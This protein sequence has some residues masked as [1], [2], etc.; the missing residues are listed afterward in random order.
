MS[1]QI[2]RRSFETRG[3]LDPRLAEASLDRWGRSLYAALRVGD[4]VFGWI[5]A[6]ARLVR[7][8]S[9]ITS[10]VAA[11][12]TA[13]ITEPPVP[14]AQMALIAIVVIALSNGGFALN[15]V[16]DRDIDKINQPGRPI[17]G[18]RIGA[19]QALVIGTGNLA[20][21]AVLSLLLPGWCI[22]VVQIDVALLVAY[23][24]WSKKMGILKGV[25]VAYLVA[26]GFLI[27]AYTFDRI[28]TVI[29]TLIGAA[30]FATLARELVKDV[31]DIE[32]DRLHD[33]RT[34]PIM[35]GPRIAYAAAFAC[36]ALCILL[37]AIPYVMGLVNN[38]YLALNLL[39]VGVFLIGWRIRHGSAR[40]CQYMIMAG[41]IL[42]L[43]AFA[44]GQT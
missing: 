32:G 20:A 22:A 13:L 4:G 31:Q 23:A 24:I 10:A 17:P 6:V 26:S 38:V 30:F 18:G 40:L 25:V 44:I 1:E 5:A 43:L 11:V 42:V 3:S 35:Y 19:S 9:G 34:V 29:G 2:E 41:S 8:N 33:A 36:I 12:L 39:A 14:A 27:G 7:L 16:Y 21:A 37:V 28:G 15:D